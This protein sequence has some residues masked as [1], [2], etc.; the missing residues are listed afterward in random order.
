MNVSRSTGCG[1]PAV[2]ELLRTNGPVAPSEWLSLLCRV[3]LERTDA[4]RAN[5][6]SL[7]MRPIA[8]LEVVASGRVVMHELSS[9]SAS[10]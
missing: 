2:L 4:S 1:C 10:A 8:Q 7:M 6:R 3:V 9:A 5:T